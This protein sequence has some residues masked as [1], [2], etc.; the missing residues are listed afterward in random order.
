[1]ALCYSEVGLYDRA[2]QVMDR[3]LGT[4]LAKSHF[5]RFYISTLK[6]DEARGPSSPFCWLLASLTPCSGR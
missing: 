6:K 1:M 5:V 3:S 2:E 4:D